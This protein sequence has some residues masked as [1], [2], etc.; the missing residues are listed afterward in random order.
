MHIPLL[1]D[2]GS[3]VKYH[4]DLLL[5][6]LAER[7]RDPGSLA[8]QSRHTAAANVLIG[9]I[10]IATGIA[11]ARL[12]GTQGRGELA[13]I[14]GWA[15][16]IASLSMFGLP[17]A[18]VFCASKRPTH[19]A[20]I[21]VSAMGLAL[22]LGIPC[23]IL[24]WCLLP[25]LLHAQQPAV[26]S[27]A[28]WYLLYIGLFALG[29]LPIAVLRAIGRI[30]MWNILRLTGPVPWVATL[31][32][33]YCAGMHR[34]VP[35]AALLLALAVVANASIFVGWMILFRARC[36]VD[37]SWWGPLLRFGTPV[38]LSSIPQYLNMRLDQLLMAGALPAQVLG[39]Y[40]VAVSWSS[41]PILI[42]SALSSVLFPRV[43]RIATATHQ[44]AVIRKA[45]L[46]TLAVSCTAAVLMASVTHRVL[47]LVFGMAFAP[48][49]TAALLLLVAS[50]F[51]ALNGVLEEG[52]KGMGQ[53]RFVLVSE[54]AGVVVTGLLLWLLL[55]PFQ[56]VGAA[57]ASLTA[58]ALTTAFLLACYRWVPT[59][60]ADGGLKDSNN[61]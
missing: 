23:G 24:G 41:A 25:P 22:L 45:F 9:V 2:L 34:A 55:R 54:A 17:D 33:G 10:G 49:T 3:K 53:P 40:A 13:A 47:P 1:R 11:A 15:M 19:A 43:S 52:L 20:R 7:F 60:G 26:I 32:Y 51:V 4:P 31:A 14:Q 8:A 42:T 50:V 35:I 46:V 56:A 61:E 29:S 12:L 28:R 37:P 27:M 36:S 58:Y 59:R 30:R 18:I 5:V 44:V 16:L 21:G 48:A 57:I 6:A 38:L 39:I